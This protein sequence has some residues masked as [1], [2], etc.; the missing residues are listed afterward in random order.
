MTPAVPW[1][2]T[3]ITRST[4]AFIEFVVVRVTTAHPHLDFS[5]FLNTRLPR[6]LAL[7][8]II[9]SLL[10]LLFLV[11]YVYLGYEPEGSLSQY[12][13]LFFSFDQ[14]AIR[15]L[16]TVPRTYSPLRGTHRKSITIGVVS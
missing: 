4:L 10:F 16:G 15:T 13:F 1:R 8:D 14:V 11:Y 6:H 5:R 12:Y 7:L 9:D 3:Y 2:S